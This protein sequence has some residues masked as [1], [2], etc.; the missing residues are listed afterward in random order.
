MTDANGKRVLK[1]TILIN[2]S[3]ANETS[4]PHE[5]WHILMADAFN[6]DQE[7]LG[8]FR[9]K[10]RQ[11]L[12]DAGMA[13]VVEKLDK[14]SENSYYQEGGVT[15]EEWL[16]EL[17]GLIAAK[18]IDVS[19]L[20][21]AQRTMLDKLVDL[22]NEISQAI[23]GVNVFDNKVTDENVLKFFIS[24][25]ES[26][27]KGKDIRSKK[28]KSLQGMMQGVN[29]QVSQSVLD[30]SDKIRNIGLKAKDGSLM[31]SKA[32]KEF[33]AELKELQK[34]GLLTEAQVDAISKKM[35]H[36]RLEN[37][38]NRERAILYAAQVITSPKN[39]VKLKKA[40]AISKGVR[41]TAKNSKRDPHV[42]AEA[43]RFA[44]IDPL[45]VQDLD[46]YI[47]TGQS[48]IYS[49]RPSRMQGTNLKVWPVIKLSDAR[50]YVKKLLDKQ[51]VVQKEMRDRI[52]IETL[53]ENGID[54]KDTFSNIDDKGEER[55]LIYDEKARKSAARN[56]KI[57]EI[58]ANLKL[59]FAAIKAPL[60]YMAET[61]KDPVTNEEMDL[62]ADERSRLKKIYNINTDYLKVS[63]VFTLIDAVNNFLVNGN[64]GGLDSILNE[65]E[66]RVDTAKMANMGLAA[67]KY[68]AVGPQ[69]YNNFMG[70]AFA[71]L[72]IFMQNIFRGQSASDTFMRMS[73]LSDTIN[74]VASA[75]HN[76]SEIALAYNKKFDKTKPNG[77]SF[78]AATNIVE[79]GMYAYLRRTPQG[80]AEEIQ[81]EF[82]KRKGH[83]EDSIARLEEGNEYEQKMA[84][85]YKEVF[86]NL[87]QANNAQEL[88]GLINNNNKEAVQWMTDKWSELH[89]KLSDLLFNMHNELLGSDINYTPTTN[90]RLSTAE[91]TKADKENA[92]DFFGQSALSRFGGSIDTQRAGVLYKV[93]P[94]ETLANDRYINLD[95]DNNMFGNLRA[96]LTDINI[97]APIRKMKGV[98]TSPSLERVLPD[99]TTRRMVSDKMREYVSDSKGRS[100]QTNDTTKKAIALVNKMSSYITQTTLGK[101]SASVVQTIPPIVNT[102]FNTMSASFNP[103]KSGYPLF[104][105]HAMFSR[106][107]N[108]FIDRAG[109]PI[110]N[111]GQESYGMF[112]TLH[113]QLDNST[114][115]SEREAIMAKIQNVYLNTFLVKSD[116]AAARASWM[117]YYMMD[118]KKQGKSI[119]N[120]DWTTHEVNTHAAD[121]AQAMVDKQQGVSDP[122]LLGSA[123]RT[124]NPA[125]KILRMVVMPFSSFRMNQSTRLRADLITLFQGTEEDRKMAM[126]SIPGTLAEVYA[127][128]ILQG[129]L[130]TTLTGWAISMIGGEDD[131]DEMLVEKGKQ[132]W[133]QIHSN[134]S[135]DILS[136][137]PLLDDILLRAANEVI[138]RMQGDANEEEI[139]EN[140]F[141]TKNSAKTF[142]S[143]GMVGI[144]GKKVVEFYDMLDMAT[145]DSYVKEVN[146]VKTRRELDAEDKEVM[147]VIVGAYAL[148]L[149]GILPAEVA[150]MSRAIKIEI[151]K[152]STKSNKPVSDSDYE[153]YESEGFEEETSETEIVEEE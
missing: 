32:R 17:G 24:M 88:E 45:M 110:G 52:E 90:R 133:R 53:E 122:N 150:T 54:K 22:I 103:K 2:N 1:P 40:A 141:S 50:V 3:R 10:I 132:R 129:F 126:R 61:G 74:G 28:P 57:D 123:F 63:E 104:D 120:I 26:M 102:I 82:N 111:R 99:Q 113:K 121:F 138:Y 125:A 76:M 87:S 71:T 14:F 36:A 9:D 39:I 107:K 136:P 92:D 83:I 56:K 11:Q 131:D 105:F 147:Q 43:K 108:Q 64:V 68:F 18:K 149:M 134:A 95:F 48:F 109:Y 128:G 114:S 77:K 67:K 12:L 116:V 144:G 73:G 29:K 93:T 8:G 23:A 58:K 142:E 98:L 6:S 94:Q 146:G 49:L 47:A 65:Y 124:K 80:T 112:D 130:Y 70:E 34:Q 100:F 84:V 38:I 91:V 81:A 15:A 148:H 153:E 101:V 19:R 140:L 118:L 117:T 72:P 106:E 152:K 42:I 44:L 96:A 151:G 62:T 60:E 79:R 37:P 59:T 115:E 31:M 69:T 145:G 35:A 21:I 46:A 135:V 89:P 25:S 16:A 20:T 97:A 5:A 85:A 66:G 27:A 139:P 78:N 4:A 30:F 127:F 55:G 119:K 41:K 33:V 51:E 7:L 75:I 143:Y 137:H 13:D 86:D